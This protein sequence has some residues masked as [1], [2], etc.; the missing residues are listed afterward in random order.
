MSNI[1]CLYPL[2]VCYRHHDFYSLFCCSSLVCASFLSHLVENHKHGMTGMCRWLQDHPNVGCKGGISYILNRID[3][4]CCVIMGLRL[5]QLYL[6]KYS[7][8]LSLLPIKYWVRGLFMLLIMFIS[9]YDQ[10]N[11]K[12]KYFYVLTHSCW[13]LGIFIWLGDLLAFLLTN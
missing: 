11:V 6:K 13:H 8:N 1:T 2:V 4:L 7:L 12:L 3:V 9:E 10:Q 5:C